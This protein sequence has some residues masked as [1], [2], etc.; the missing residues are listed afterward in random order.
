MSEMEECVS[1]G[2]G[3]H[4]LTPAVTGWADSRVEVKYAACA[5]A[6]L[7]AEEVSLENAAVL[8]TRVCDIVN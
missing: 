3:W 2:R 7:L 6:V 4:L 8:M 5:L 1:G